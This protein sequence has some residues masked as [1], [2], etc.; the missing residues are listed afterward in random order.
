MKPQPDGKYH[1]Q[2]IQNN[3]WKR[4]MA[5]RIFGFREPRHSKNCSG[6]SATSVVAGATREYFIPTTNN[7]EGSP[8]SPPGEQSLVLGI[9]Y[10]FLQLLTSGS[11]LLFGRVKERNIG[12]D[13]RTRPRFNK[14]NAYLTILR[15]FPRSIIVADNIQHMLHYRNSTRM[16]G[17][18]GVK[19]GLRG[20]L[21]MLTY[22]TRCGA[23]Q[24]SHCSQCHGSRPILI[25]H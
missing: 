13:S 7:P 9:A 11:L 16:E 17:R 12:M 18:C 21:A 24:I 8:P 10:D 20:R 3:V 15:R 14:F 2:G 4:I 19:Y 6:R 22:S 5:L 25:L 1:G 23:S